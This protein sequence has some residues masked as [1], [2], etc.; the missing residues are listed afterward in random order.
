MTVVH[1]INNLAVGGT[2]RL[3]L[4]FISECAHAH[5]SVHS[6]IIVLG[7]V[8]QTFEGHAID[9]EVEYLGFSGRYRNILQTVACIRR[10]R[11]RLRELS[12]D[13]VHSWL[14]VSDVFCMLAIKNSGVRHIAE[15]V[16]RRANRHA[17]SLIH[18][19]RVSFTARLFKARHSDFVAVSMACKEHAME[20]YQ[21]PA[22]RITVAFNAVKVDQFS[23]HGGWLDVLAPD[24]F[25]IGTISNLIEEK[26]HLYL[27][28]AAALL[29]DRVPTL[30]V[31]IAG[32]GSLRSALEARAAELGLESCVNF[33]GRLAAAEDFYDMIHVFVVPSIYAEGLPTTILEAMASKLP[34]IATDIGGAVEAVRHDKEGLIVPSRD[35]SGLA[36]AVERLYQDRSLLSRLGSAAAV[37]A[38]DAFSIQAMTTKI[39]SKVYARPSA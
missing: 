8:A 27:L 15:V 10:L 35:A 23:S 20:H 16:D 39:V 31:L 3:M 12:P 26:G 4:D 17:A 11:N 1:V 33:L 13:I 7:N 34:V 21:I 37:R 19:L 36:D 18:R 25:V 2:Q 9:A 38:R 14:W 29:K 28:E 5:P 24:P 32:D 6:H 22:E 30:R